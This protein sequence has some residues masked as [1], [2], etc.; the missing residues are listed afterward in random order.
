MS[1][2]G[3]RKRDVQMDLRVVFHGASTSASLAA[4]TSDAGEGFWHPVHT[5][6][7]LLVVS[8]TLGRHGE[9]ILMAL[10]RSRM[11][12]QYPEIAMSVLEVL[13]AAEMQAC[14]RV[15]TRALWDSFHRADAGG[16]QGSGGFRRNPFSQRAA[17]DGALRTRQQRRRR[18]DGGAAARRSGAG[19]DH[20]AAGRAA[21]ILRATPPQAWRELTQ[22]PCAASVHVVDRGRGLGA[23]QR[24][25]RKPI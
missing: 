1:F 9:E 2:S 5:I 17:R 4:K 7:Q 8:V 15:T 13:T 22:V 10:P 16:G 6:R 12:F 24:C 19:G 25:A 14:D 20:A 11:Q 23:A 21:R 18:H 3:G